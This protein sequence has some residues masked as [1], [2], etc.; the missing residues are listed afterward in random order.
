MIH[1]LFASH[2]RRS[3]AP[4]AWLFRTTGIYRGTRRQR[5]SPRTPPS[6]STRSS[7]RCL[8]AKKLKTRAHFIKDMHILQLINHHNMYLMYISTRAHEHYSLLD[9][10]PSMAYSSRSCP[11]HQGLFQLFIVLHNLQSFRTSSAPSPT[12]VPM[13]RSS[14][15]RRLTV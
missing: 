13:W 5:M 4:C 14:S 9:T 11:R 6:A 12:A 15:R 3:S 2:G 1:D 8:C 7:R 10:I